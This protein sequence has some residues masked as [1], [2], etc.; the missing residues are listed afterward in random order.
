[1]PIDFN[2]FGPVCY[3]LLIPLG[4]SLVQP[5]VAL[6]NTSIHPLYKSVRQPCKNYEQSVERFNALIKTIE[7]IAQFSLYFFL[8]QKGWLYGV[9]YLGMIGGAVTF[10]LLYGAGCWVD[11]KLKTNMNNI[12]TGT[13]LYYEGIKNIRI[14][15]EW[16]LVSVIVGGFLTKE[17]EKSK[18]AT[19]WDARRTRV[20]EWCASWFFD[21][22]KPAEKPKSTEKTPTSS[23]PSQT[24]STPSKDASPPS[25]LPTKEATPPPSNKEAPRSDEGTKDS[26][27]GE[28]VDG[29]KNVSDGK[30]E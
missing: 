6:F 25:D 23:A 22:A 21:K 1:M 12:C 4:K 9:Y 3:N 5:Y 13:W 20:A 26:V 29:P 15:R 28:V 19:S 18:T 2:P 27:G 10:S 7:L 8:Y 30:S 16:M 24:T 17:H 11:N 14:S